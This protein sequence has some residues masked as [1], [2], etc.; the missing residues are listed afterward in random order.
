MQVET[1]HA[2]LHIASLAIFDG[3][4]PTQADIHA[5]VERKLALVPRFR[6]RLRHVPLELA[7]P[8]WE[9]DPTFDLS[10]HLHRLAVPPPGGSEELREVAEQLLSEPLDHSVPLWSDWVL[11]GLDQ[12][13]WALLTKVHHTMVDGIAG[14]DLLTTLLD[15]TPEPA[16]EPAHPWRPAPTSGTV[17]LVADALREAAAL[18]ARELTGLPAEAA[19]TWRGLRHPR[20]LAAAG[21][22]SLSGVA[23]FARALLPTSR[24]SLAGPLGG[25]RGYHWTEVDLETVCAIR[26]ELGGTINDVVLAA[27]TAGFRELLI[28]RGEIPGP[29]SVRT[30]VPVSVR[31]PDERGHLDNRVS[32]ILAALPVELDDPEDRLTEVAVRMRALKDSHEAEVGQSLTTLADS[33]PAAGLTAFLH[34]VF[35]TPHR[36]LT[37]VTT[38]V[39]G[40]K[41]RLY[42]AGRPMVATYPYV[43]IADRLRT[44]IAITSY[45][46]QLLLGVTT[47]HD[48]VPD[49]HVL[50][51]GI[52]AGF[53]GMAG[54]AT[55]A[56]AAHG[57]MT[58][59]AH[60]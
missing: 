23:G 46:G 37:T 32:A 2:P 21:R 35:R 34:V 36:N 58:A 24:S 17:R 57:S 13:R 41:E 3:P 50:V 42:L 7:R 1:R 19:M 44:G 47:D 54:R 43:P 45:E 4:V 31:R 14:T 59:G 22:A 30:L 9:D 28:A 18:R 51:E 16:P 39:P 5:A 11:E 26:H 8:V 52:D 20:E 56:T 49:A 27:I 6:Q 55:R 15:A 33:L 60:R 53:A 40:P 25:Q 29:R 48:S 10:Q 12:D 38:N